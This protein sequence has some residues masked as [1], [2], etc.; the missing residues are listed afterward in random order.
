MEYYAEKDIN[1]ATI[2]VCFNNINNT[3]VTSLWNKSFDQSF[4]IYRGTNQIK[5]Q[6]PKIHLIPGEYEVILYIESN[7]TVL[8]RIDGFRQIT[9][10]TPSNFDFVKIPDI[11]QGLYIEDFS[12]QNL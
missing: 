11:S 9:V 2:A 1:N 8:E 12:V 4:K 7:G 10:G 5:F 6:V 3:R